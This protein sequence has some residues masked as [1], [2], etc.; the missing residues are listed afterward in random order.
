VGGLYIHINYIKMRYIDL[1]ES[2]ILSEGRVPR[3]ERIEIFKDVDCVIVAPLIKKAASE[4]GAY[5]K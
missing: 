2:F 1:F 3:D 4:Y 5:T